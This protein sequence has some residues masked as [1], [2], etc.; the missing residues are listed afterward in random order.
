MKENLNKLTRQLYAMGYTREKCPNTVYWSDWQNFGYTWETMLGFTWETP[1]GLLIEGQS[2]A[3]RT[4]AISDIFYQDI[5]YCPENDN[6]LILCPYQRKNCQY[7]S[8]PM[9]F[10]MCPCH[11]TRKPY[12][13]AHSV[14]K[15][16]AEH[17]QAAKS[18][19]QYMEI[20]SGSRCVCVIGNNGVQGGFQRIKYDVND[21]IMVGCRNPVCVIRKQARDLSRVNIFYDL[22]RTWITRIGFLEEKKVTITKGLKAFDEA[23]ARTDAEIWIKS[24]ERKRNPLTSSSIIERPKLTPLD[25]SYEHSSK[26]HQ[27][28][29]VYDYFEFHYEVENIRIARS[30]HRD[31]LQDLQDIA[32]GIQVSGVIV[33]FGAWLKENRLGELDGETF[34]IDAEAADRYFEGRFAAFQQAVMALQQLNEAKFIHEHDQVQSLIFNLI[35]TFTQKYGDYVLWDDGMEPIPLEEFLR[36]ARPDVRYCIGAVLDYK[37]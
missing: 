5:R 35:E 2:N 21:C 4:V 6:P 22:R 17:E 12:D 3:G 9:K 27:R 20:A 23:I 14:E 36:K 15:I 31:L 30:D 33:R 26:Y 19:R 29:G 11:Q 25:R 10:L 37:H 1:C 34:T 7:V 13:Y 16:E 32:N 24:M 28:R 18:H 8:Q